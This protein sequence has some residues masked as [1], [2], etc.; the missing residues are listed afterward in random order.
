MS[1][2]SGY[3]DGSH[4]CLKVERF[5][6]TLNVIVQICI[7]QTE[8]LLCFDCNL[9]T[10]IAPALSTLSVDEMHR[11]NISKGGQ[12][13]SKATSFE[14]EELYDATVIRDLLNLHLDEVKFPFIPSDEICN[15][16]VIQAF[17]QVPHSDMIT[18]ILHNHPVT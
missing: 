9:M 2:C 17:L 10:S 8:M 1:E 18:N 16:G 12:V 3:G 5:T 4:Q 7:I 15:P 6:H 11:E 14:F 13:S